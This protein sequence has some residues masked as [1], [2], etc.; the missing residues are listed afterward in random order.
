MADSLDQA[1][2]IVEEHAERHAR[3]GPGR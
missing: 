3:S 2:G 1:A